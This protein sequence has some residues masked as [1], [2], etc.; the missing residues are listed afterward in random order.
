M[1]CCV[2]LHRCGTARAIYVAPLGEYCL[3]DDFAY[4]SNLIAEKAS[5][6]QMR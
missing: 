1:A 6:L 5:A 4:K 2:R 3:Y